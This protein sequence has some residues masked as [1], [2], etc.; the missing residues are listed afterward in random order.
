M[1]TDLILSQC[2][3]IYCEAFE[4]DVSEC[5]AVFSA[6][7]SDLLYLSV[8]EKIVSILFSVDAVYSDGQSEKPFKYIF[9]A[10]TD[11]ACRG[12]GCMTSLIKEAVEFARVGNCSGVYLYPATEK[13][14][15]YYSKLGFE[16]CFGFDEINISDVTI[17]TIS[18]FES[19][20]EKRSGSYI[21]CK[22]SFIKLA[23]KLM[24]GQYLSDDDSAC[25]LLKR[26]E[27]TYVDTVFGKPLI[28]NNSKSITARVKGD[29]YPGMAFLF[30]EGIDKTAY[31][32]TILD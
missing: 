31:L 24:D 10:A 3:K 27:E 32:T 7:D 13:L 22:D 16:D 11:K 2:K 8:D 19:F 30:D 25:L 23:A 1:H 20:K 29:K 15:M 21:T 4:S 17:G 28:H 18:D 26:D 14:R 12:K 9:A 6:L 5:D